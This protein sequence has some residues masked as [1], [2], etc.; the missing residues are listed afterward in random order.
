[1][2]YI[3]FAFDRYY[4]QGGAD[5]I[6]FCTSDVDEAH[7]LYRELIDPEAERRYDYVQ[8]Y[9]TLECRNVYEKW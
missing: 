5:D 7:D 3:V 6:K 2:R 8:V 9:D 1:M 4:P